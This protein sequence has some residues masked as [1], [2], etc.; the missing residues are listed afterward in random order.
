MALG[1]LLGSAAYNSPT[2]CA[3]MGRTAQVFATQWRHTLIERANR[4]LAIA[5]LVEASFE[6]S[7][8]L[9]QWRFE[10]TKLA[11]D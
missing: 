9:F 11:L 5:V 3:E 6:A 7:K 8:P 10:A 2:T 4:A 1:Y